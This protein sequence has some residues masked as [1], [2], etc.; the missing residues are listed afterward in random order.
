[1]TPERLADIKARCE[2]PA[3]T[4]RPWKPYRCSYADECD[5]VQYG[6]G[7]NGASFDCSSDECHHPIPLVDLQFMAHAREDLPDTVAENEQ[8]LAENERLRKIVA[9]TQTVYWLIRSSRDEMDSQLDDANR[10][11]ELLEGEE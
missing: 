9:A 11:L 10:L 3:L 5:G 6:C 4:A 7:L 1:M 8:L 2:N